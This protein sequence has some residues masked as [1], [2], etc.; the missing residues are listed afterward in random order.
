MLQLRVDQEFTPALHVP[1][2]GH[3]RLPYAG[4]ILWA[5]SADA[6]GALDS[7]PNVSGDHRLLREQTSSF[8]V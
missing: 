6:P 2:Q 1:D 8:R 5:V 3:L 4:H 7:D